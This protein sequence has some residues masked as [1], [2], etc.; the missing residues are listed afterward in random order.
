MVWSDG[1]LPMPV[2]MSTTLARMQTADKCQTTSTSHWSFRTAAA[3]AVVSFDWLMSVDLNAVP[4]TH[5]AEK[6]ALVD[7]PT[8][9]QHESDLSGVTQEQIDTAREEVAHDMGW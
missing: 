4:I 1:V 9:L 7:L 2:P 6:Q 3:D 5:P 8:R